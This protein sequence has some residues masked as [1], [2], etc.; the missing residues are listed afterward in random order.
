MQAMHL[1]QQARSHRRRLLQ[2]LLDSH[3]S[4]DKTNTRRRFVPQNRRQMHREQK[5]TKA[6][7]RCDGT[8]QGQA[9]TC[10][11]PQNEGKFE[12]M[13]CSMNKPFHLMTP[14]ERTAARIAQ[15]RAIS[16]KLA[17]RTTKS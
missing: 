1:L 9:R 7:V 13:R 11:S 10:L 6:L 4:E 2:A 16:E 12:I 3:Q 8:G 14:A 17:A 15:N 5:V